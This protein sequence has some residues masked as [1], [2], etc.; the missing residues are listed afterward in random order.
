M[1]E[2]RDGVLQQPAQVRQLAHVHAWHIGGYAGLIGHLV[3]II[4]A[5]PS[6][7][8]YGWSPADAVR[9]FALFTASMAVGPLIGGWI[10]DA[11]IGKRRG[12]VWGMWLQTLGIFALAGLGTLP[13]LVGSFTDA[14]VRA[15]I[16]EADVP[17]A[18]L[19]LDEAAS[20][21]LS[22]AAA[23][24]ADTPAEAAAL[25]RTATGTYTALTAGFYLSLV[26]FGLG[27]A[28]SPTLF[29]I[30]GRVYDRKGGKRAAGYTLL[31]MSAML[32]FFLGGLLSGS[33]ATNLG[34][35]EALGVSG[36]M[37]AVA[38]V[39]LMR[40]RIPSSR[41]GRT[42]E[43]AEGQSTQGAAEASSTEQ[44]AGLMA[45]MSLSRPERRRVGA[46]GALALA[47]TVFIAAFDQWGGTFSLYVQNTSDRTIGGFEVPTLWI[48][49][50]QALFVV[51]IGPVNLWFWAFLERRERPLTPPTKMALGLFVTSASFLVMCVTFTE[52]GAMGADPGKTNLF[53]PLAFYWVI[54]FGQCALLPI[55]QAFVSR[56][57]PRRLLSTCMGV[58]GVFAAAGHWL[59]GE[60][61]ALVP[62]FGIDSVYLGV[63]VGT[64]TADV[65][66]LAGGRSL[67]RLVDTPERPPAE[68]TSDT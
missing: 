62:S 63:A 50:A 65:A 10:A 21:R 48:H 37:C 64:A 17:I 61:G 1:A 41:G 40:I 39:I 25:L 22:E 9:L 3:L 53:W 18:H 44:Q 33:F 51:I 31:F 19:A 55:G 35:R 57:A 34:W 24:H 13:A 59:A 4:T 68:A 54:T 42:D 16:L 66:M 5:S 28:L 58:W 32:G 14:P 6:E 46:I 43:G 26:I 8:G 38:A 47:Y 49:S 11:F 67:M 56:Q 30:V 15:V 29:A 12:A 36:M 23:E 20:R 45:L 52:V 27:Y 7:Y 2:S 60:V